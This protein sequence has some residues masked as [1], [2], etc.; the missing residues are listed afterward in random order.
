VDKQYSKMKMGG[1]K[2]CETNVHFQ[3]KIPIKGRA[4]FILFFSK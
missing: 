2:I 4:V 1:I 3:A